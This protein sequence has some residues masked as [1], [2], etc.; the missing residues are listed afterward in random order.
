M[1]E[2]LSE[3]LL[4]RL[5][6]DTI[7]HLEETENAML[8]GFHDEVRAKAHGKGGAVTIPEGVATAIRE[9][10]L[11]RDGLDEIAHKG[12]RPANNPRCLICEAAAAKKAKA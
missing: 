5:L 9:L 4:K 6:G 1:A 11:I 7:Y 2:G 8:T 10:D 3:D 12:W